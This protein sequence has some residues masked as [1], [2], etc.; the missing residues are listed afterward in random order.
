MWAPERSGARAARSALQALQEALAG[1]RGWLVGGL[2]RELLLAEVASAPAPAPPRTSLLDAARARLDAAASAAAG[3]VVSV[4][5]DIVTPEDP[6]RLARALARAL[7]GVAFLLHAEHGGWRVL[8]AEGALQVDVEPLRGATIEQDLR[9]RDFTID[10]IAQPFDGGELIDPTG[11]LADLAARRLRVAGAGALAA[12]P[13]RALR[14][15]RLAAALELAIEPQTAALLAEHAPQL[16]RV[17]PERCFAELRLMLCGADPA[18]AIALLDRFG[19]LAVLLP[20]LVACQGL[21]QSR[22]HHLDVY[23]HTLAVLRA[24]VAVE[25]ALLAPQSRGRPG[26]DLEV[27]AQAIGEERRDA[28]A[29]AMAAPLADGM[30]RSQALRLG[31]LLHDIG[32]PATRALDARG[33]VTFVGHDVQGERIGRAMLARLRTSSHLQAHVGA[34]VRHHLRLGFLVHEPMPLA[35]RTLY[36]Y[37]RSSGSVA[38]DVTLLSVA[39]RLATRGERSEQAIAEHLALAATVLPEALAYHRCG[40]PAP[41]L[42]GDEL[43]RAL[44]LAPGPA[45]GTLLEEL[46]AAQFAGEVSDRPGALAYAR[47]LNAS[48]REAP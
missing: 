25:R 43:A 36:G 17:A 6:R 13:L 23:E 34:L 19:L 46:R 31:A 16:G 1:E 48:G 8:A 22:F 14:A 40:P 38:L 42:R 32:K 15:V 3:P 35:R 7:G 28:L 21:M 4:D 47:A 9:A 45:I 29:C 18:G 26:G 10:A 33:R 30:T 41:L 39:D 37:L 20:E 24:A 5:V 2:I 27:L 11:G 44:G 12:D